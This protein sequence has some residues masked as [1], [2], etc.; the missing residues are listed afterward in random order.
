[1]QYQPLGPDMFYPSDARELK[2][3]VEES[4]ALAGRS[5]PEPEGRHRVCIIPHG[6]YDYILP[7]LSAAWASV[8]RSSF[9]RIV[10]LLPVHTPEP[11]H[12]EGIFLPPL[13]QLICP[14]GSSPVESMQSCRELRTDSR[15]Y[16]EEPALDNSLPFIS[17]LFPGVPL[18]PLFTPGDSSRAAAY[19]ASFL[20][21]FDTPETLYAVS[22]NLTGVL[23]VSAASAQEHRLL[24][25][26]GSAGNGKAHQPL[27]EPK[28]K[29]EISPCNPAALEALRRSGILPGPYQMLATSRSPEQRGKIV[30]YGALSV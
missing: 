22:S 25:L 19:L 2:R 6:L 11:E 4:L 28:R 26:L 13:D 5:L 21:S 27:L 30:S 8:S 9:Q 12:Q 7:T 23:P 29:G 20:G 17:L 16:L 3:L 24:S 14:L 1:M 15:F 18:L 10:L